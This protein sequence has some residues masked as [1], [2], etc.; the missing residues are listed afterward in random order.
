MLAADVSQ[1]A[2]MIDK[3]VPA[4]RQACEQD[5]WPASLVHCIVATKRGDLSALEKC[6]AAMPKPLQD[7]LERRIKAAR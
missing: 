2:A 4:M 7:K 3:M 5:G 1:A 6:N